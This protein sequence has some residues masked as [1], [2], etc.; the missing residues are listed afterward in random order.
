MTPRRPHPKSHARRKAPRPALPQQEPDILVTDPEFLIINKPA[1]LLVHPAPGHPDGTLTDFL[2]SRHPELT[3]VGSRERPGI[4]HRLD[5]ETSGVMVIARTQRAYLAL[6]R[7]F[8]QHDTVRKTYLAVL[9]GAPA[10]RTG[11]IDKP[12]GRKPWDPKRMAVVESG[13]ARAVTHWTVL[14]KHGPLALVEFQ[15][16]TGRT[17]QIRVHAAHLGHPVVGDTLYGHDAADRRLACPPSHHLL[18]ALGLEF[19]HPS[20]GKPQRFFVEPPPELVYAH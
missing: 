1:G 17:H 16:E 8:E 20:T 7:Q 15:I 12:I 2:C 14:S 4:V 3:Q 11:T 13:G 18:H 9:H 6:R 19:L 10:A 5:R